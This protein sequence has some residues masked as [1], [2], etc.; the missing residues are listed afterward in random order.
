[1][2]PRAAISPGANPAKYQQ[3]AQE[4][5]RLRELDRKAQAYFRLE[6]ELAD[7]RVLV[8]DPAND[9]ELREMAQQEIAR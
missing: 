6:Q 1:M 4:H 3:L 2:A 5:S 8:T 7:N 9:A